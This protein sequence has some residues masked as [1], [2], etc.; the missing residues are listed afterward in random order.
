M[1][2]TDR[3]VPAYLRLRPALQ[4]MAY[5]RANYWVPGYGEPR[6]YVAL[7]SSIYMCYSRNGDE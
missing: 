7:R 1:G 2:C 5:P 6:P 3:Q 4:A